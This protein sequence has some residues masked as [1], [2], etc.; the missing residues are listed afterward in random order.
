MQPHV[1]TDREIQEG[2]L[3][4]QAGTHFSPEQIRIMAAQGRTPTEVAGYPTPQ[5]G[6]E[7]E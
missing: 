4:V 7:S 3:K 6:D 1:P 5:G 2:L